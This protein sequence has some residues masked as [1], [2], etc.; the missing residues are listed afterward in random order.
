M[1]TSLTSCTIPTGALAPGTGY[2]LE[3]MLNQYEHEGTDWGWQIE[4]RTGTYLAYNTPADPI[5][6]ALWLLGSE[7]VGLA[8]LR[9]KRT[10]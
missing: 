4:G 1:P 3:I 7:L 5:P 6:G 10:R 2:L 8:A 9:R